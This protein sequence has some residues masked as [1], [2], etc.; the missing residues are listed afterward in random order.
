M[1]PPKV[2]CQTTIMFSFLK[3]VEGRQSEQRYQQAQGKQGWGPGDS[4]CPG[5]GRLLPAGHLKEF[6]APRLAWTQWPKASSVSPVLYSAAAEPVQ[7][8][9]MSAWGLGRRQRGGHGGGPCPRKVQGTRCLKK[10]Q[11]KVT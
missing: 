2:M 3:Q 1:R 11:G 6:W 4:C 7:P 9:A 5:P 8:S 10:K